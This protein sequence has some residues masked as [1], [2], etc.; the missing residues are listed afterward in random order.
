MGSTIQRL[1]EH[2]TNELPQVS[3]RYI[4]GIIG[5]RPSQYAKTPHLWNAVFRALEWDAISLAWDL[6]GDR[7]ESFLSASRGS[8]EVLG[9]S[10]TQPFK[11]AV[12]PL[13][14]E[15]DALAAQI[16]AVNTVVRKPDGRLVGFNTDGQGAIDA[17]TRSIPGRGAPLVPELAGRSIILI[18]AGGAGRAV[19]FFIAS[20]MERR[21][22]LRIVNRNVSRAQELARAVRKVFGVGD[23]AGEEHLT[24]LLPEA[25]V[26]INATVKGQ[27][28]WR[29]DP[30]GEAFSLEPYSSLAPAD[31][32]RLEADRSL[33]AAA[34]H[35][36]FARS[37]RD[38]DSNNS[39]GREAIAL[40]PERSICF[41]LIYSPLESRFLADARYAGH[42]TMN[43]KWM[44][45]AQAAD[46]FARK[47]CVPVL[48]A[49]DAA[50][51]RAYHRVFETMAAIW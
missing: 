21:G 12:V 15:L 49:D 13:L 28:G 34:S 37:R 50:A 42:R 48:A 14:D 25:D 26:V 3:P 19:A 22:R 32:E 36:W 24:D 29:R 30:S 44:N 2:V 46:A 5:D 7:L 39:L 47:V 33:D 8:A 51:D 16:G 31:P 20:H 9:F 40:L 35:D 43:G 4:T 38:V 45:I 41:D 1:A 27:S 18:G 6:P 17:L 11:I 10:V 23:A